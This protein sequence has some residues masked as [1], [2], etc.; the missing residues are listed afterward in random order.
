M[1]TEGLLYFPN[2][3]ILTYYQ[4]ILVKKILIFI[5]LFPPF[6]SFPLLLLVSFLFSLHSSPPF[7]LFSF[8]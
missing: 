6:L 5:Y 3:L 7:F 1:F 2:Y 8:F 4:N